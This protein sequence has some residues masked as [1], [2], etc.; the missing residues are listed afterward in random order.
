MILYEDLKHSS[1]TKKTIRRK[2]LFTIW[3]LASILYFSQMKEKEKNK[4]HTW[5]RV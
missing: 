1:V 4:M 3:D 5:R 2:T